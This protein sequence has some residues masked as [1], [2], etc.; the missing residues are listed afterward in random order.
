MLFLS[1]EEL[2]EALR[3]KEVDGIIVDLYT[4][5]F[6]KDLFNGS[7]FTVNRVIEYSFTCGMIIGENAS[8]LQSLFLDYAADSEA[9]Q[10][11]VIQSAQDE[12]TEVNN[13]APT[14]K[15]TLSPLYM[16]HIPEENHKKMNLCQ[17]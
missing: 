1:T 11:K 8:R 7:W 2:V 12:E 17:R 4:A 9:A 14:D 10:L 5:G 3:S 13:T 6:R 15:S 16:P